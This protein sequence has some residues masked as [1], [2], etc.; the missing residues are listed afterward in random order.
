MKIAIAISSLLMICLLCCGGKTPK[1]ASDTV[2]PAAVRSAVT[3]QDA[4]TPQDAAADLIDYLL[5]KVDRA[6]GFVYELGMSALVT[7]ETEELEGV[8]V[9]QLVFLGTGSEDQFVKEIHY[10]ISHDGVIYEYDPIFD[11]W[12]CVFFP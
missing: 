10:A 1:P 2:S 7:G 4:G 9:C 5:S 3:E 8:G 6:R 11:V 12:N